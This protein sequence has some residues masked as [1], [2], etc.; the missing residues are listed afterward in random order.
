MQLPSHSAYVTSHHTQMVE[1]LMSALHC[2]VSLAEEV[3]NCPLLKESAP[4]ITSVTT[5]TTLRLVNYCWEQLNQVWSARGRCGDKGQRSNSCTATYVRRAR[6]LVRM[7]HDRCMVAR[8]PGLCLVS[9][10]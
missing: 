6:S 5:E 3:N 1:L 8:D 2:L 4:L 10:N 7:H 9:A